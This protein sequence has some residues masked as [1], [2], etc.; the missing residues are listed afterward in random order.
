MPLSSWLFI[1]EQESIW[2]ER[3]HGCSVIVAGPGSARAH[4]LFLNDDALEA[5]QVAT[6][7]RLTQAGWFLWGSDLSGVCNPEQPGARVTRYRC[8][9]SSH[10]RTT[11]VREERAM[12]LVVLLIILLLLFGG[13]GFYLGGPA[14]GGGL[15]GLILLVLIVLL[16][17]GRLGSRA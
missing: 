8:C 3:P 6:A 9:W 2:I 7:E 14:I 17:T 12:N 15:G 4:L 10:D 16:L 11:E 1:R 5:Y 13:G